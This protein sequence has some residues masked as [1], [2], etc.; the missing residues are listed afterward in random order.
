MMVSLA[1]FSIDLAENA[2]SEA[3]S[4]VPPQRHTIKAQDVPKLG[5]SSIRDSIR[6]QLHAL[7]IGDTHPDR[8]LSSD[9]VKSYPAIIGECV[10]KPQTPTSSASRPRKP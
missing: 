4:S 3:H 2:Q 6:E 8:G 7:S 10:S 9:K 1:A 5:S